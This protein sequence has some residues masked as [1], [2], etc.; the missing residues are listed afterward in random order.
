[1]KRMVLAMLLFV[2]SAAAETQQRSMQVRLFWQHPPAHISVVPLRAALRMCESCAPTRLKALLEITAKGSS[3]TAGSRSSPILI[4]TGQVRISGNGFPPFTVD[5]E[6]RIQARDDSLLLT[7]TMPLE[8]YVTAVLQGESASFKSDEALKAMAV[9]ARTY[10]VRFGSRHRFEGFDFCDTTHCQ[11][12]RLGNE[13]PRARAA[14]AATEGELL[15][16]EGR[17]AAAYYHRS[18]GGEIDD[19]K[20]L[21]PDLHV[22]YLKRH[23][24]DYCVRI[25]DEWQSEISKADLARALGRP[26][27]SVRVVARGDSG[28]VQ[29][30]LISDRAITATDFRLAVGRTLGWDILRSDLYEE[31]DRGDRIV[32]RGRG[33]GHGVG[34]CQSGAESM[35]EQGHSYREILAYYYP[36]TAVGINAQGLSWE[37]LPGES[38]DLVSTD[39]NDAPVLLPA[40]ERALHFAMERTGLQIRTHP[41][42]KVYPTMAIY[43]NATGEPG[44]VAASTLKSTVRLQPVSTLQRTQSLDSTLRHEFLHMLIEGDAKPGTPLWFREGLVVYLA[45]DSSGRDRATM[46]AEAI[47]RAISSRQTQAEVRLAYR[48][49]AALVRDLDRRYTR[50]KLIDWLRNGLPDD[51]RRSATS[52]GVHE[53]AK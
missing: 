10:A 25:P 17:P 24:D 1:M 48:Q 23:H 52:A 34:L 46:S 51:V 14:A 42:L 45:G 27:A 33:Q 50:A 6:L 7:F 18:C 43:R 5:N 36:G 29:R 35:G 9:A 41:Q 11:D 20:A 44:W 32:F 4:L 8:E 16:F 49:A 28:R 30:L 13:S 19:A 3:V 53:V 39:R 31:E 2:V 12:L 38:F 40:A 47:D 26:V 37:N 21:E 15:W 22:R